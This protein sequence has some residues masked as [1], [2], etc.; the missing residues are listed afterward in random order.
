[1]LIDPKLPINHRYIMHGAPLTG[2]DGVQA[3]I[4]VAG[5]FFGR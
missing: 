3:N 2:F 5:Q 1:M 4:V